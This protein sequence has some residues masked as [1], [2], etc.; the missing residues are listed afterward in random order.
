VRTVIARPESTTLACSGDI[1]SVRETFFSPVD[2]Q[3]AVIEIQV[4]TEQPLEVQASFRD[5]QLEWPA[6]IGR[7][8]VKWTESLHGFAFGEERQKFAALVG[9]R[10]RPRRSLNTRPITARPDAF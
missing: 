9:S 5:F 3:G 8:Y 10:A 1:F 2:Q 4:E 6:A 7:T